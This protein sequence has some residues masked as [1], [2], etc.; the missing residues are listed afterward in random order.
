M[1]DKYRTLIYIYTSV[2]K[3]GNLNWQLI[4]VERI[5]MTLL[6]LTR[7]LIFHQNLDNMRHFRFS[8]IRF[9]RVVFCNGGGFLSV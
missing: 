8:E 7:R 2:T 5:F 1:I 4:A 3:E 6:V 9:G